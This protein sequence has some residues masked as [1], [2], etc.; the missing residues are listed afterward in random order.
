MDPEAGGRSADRRWWLGLG[1]IVLAGLALRVVYVWFY[2]RGIDLRGDPVYYHDAANLLADGK[3]FINPFAYEE[4]RIVQ[5]ADHP[6][7][8]IVYLAV[9]SLLG[10]RSVTAHL[11]ASCLLGAGAVGMGGLAGREVAGRRVGWLT[12]ALMALY[13]NVWRFDGMVLSETMVIFTVMLTVFLA[14]RCWRQPSPKALA[15]VG[16]AVAAATLAR[17]ELGLLLPLLLVPMAIG[18]A[19]RL[20]RPAWRLVGVGLAAAGALLGPWV[21]FNLI[22]FD[23][24]VLLSSQMEVTLAVSNCESVYYGDLIGYWDLGCG[25]EILDRHQIRAEFSEAE[26]QRVLLGDTLDYMREHRDRIPTVIAARLGRITGVFRPRQQINIDV[27]VELF[28]RRVMEA[29]TISYWLL[30]PFAVGGIVV[31]RRRG[32]PVYPV[33]APAI[34]VLIT[35]ALFYSSMRF[36]ASAEG[37][38]CLLAAVGIAALAARWWPERDPTTGSRGPDSVAGRTAEPESAIDAPGMADGQSERETSAGA[39]AATTS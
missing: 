2:R 3:G 16:V 10:L 23:R 27:A 33:L 9:F 6:P 32:V 8:Y 36:R 17:S 7:L 24:L 39:S 11:L 31:L 13:P 4:G 34:T 19:R 38:L 14:Y 28:P 15:W 12:A 18:T 21:V 22:R 1:L 26:A 5:G 37:P 30:V 25:R 35:V 29:A 20:G